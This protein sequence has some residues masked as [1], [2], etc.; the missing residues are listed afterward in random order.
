MFSHSILTW[1][2]EAGILFFVLYVCVHVRLKAYFADRA[3]VWAVRMGG[4]GG[5]RRQ[6]SSMFTH[7]ATTS[8]VNV[9]DRPFLDKGARI[10][11]PLLVSPS[12]GLPY[13]APRSVKY[14]ESF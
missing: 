14:V 7:Q 5:R 8:E 9:M 1:Q 4:P 10:P 11:P 12:L 13:F 6:L 2:G 3:A